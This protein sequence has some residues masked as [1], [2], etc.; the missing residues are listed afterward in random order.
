MSRRRR[1]L[2]VLLLAFIAGYVKLAFD[3]NAVV[4]SQPAQKQPLPLS[5]SMRPVYKISQESALESEDV[6]LKLL[7]SNL[8]LAQLAALAAT[9]PTDAE[10]RNKLADAY[11]R[12]GLDWSAYH[13]FHEVETLTGG[14]FHAELVLAR[15]W[16][17][18]Q[19]YS[20]ART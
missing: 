4:Q 18:W 14:D 5:E 2:I 9:D 10:S 20:M 15:V 1:Y 19:D 17:K 7:D 8:E 6:R 12:A 11:F 16:D 13:L 3:R